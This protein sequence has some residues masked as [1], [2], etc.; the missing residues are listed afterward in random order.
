MSSLSFA[1]G[2]GKVIAVADVGSDSVGAAVVHVLPGEPA[3][4][5][6]TEKLTLPFEDRAPEQTI[7]GVLSLLDDACKKVTA[8]Y[9]AV[10]AKKRA[11][12][13]VGA[14]AVIHPKWTSTKTLQNSKV[15][16]LEERITEG[17]IEGLARSTIGGE[18]QLDR[19]KLIEASVVSVELNE[20]KVRNIEGKHAHSILV[21]T[22]LSECEPAIRTG[23]TET[24]RRSFPSSAPILRSA[25]HA[26]FS[27]LH[28]VA[29]QAR[30]QT[31]VAIESDS[32]NCIVIRKDSVMEHI[33]VAEGTSTILKKIASDALAEETLS[34]MRMMSRD[35][36]ETDACQKLSASLASIEPELARVF[37]EAFTRLTTIQRLPNALTIVAKPEFAPWLRAFFSRVDFGHFTVT[38][39]PFAPTVLSAEG[40]ACFSEAPAD[41]DISVLLA[42]S[43]VNMEELHA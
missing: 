34:L 11:R 39:Q 7:S 17:I 30:N 10:Y 43:F 12:P 38:T 40:L 13:V 19:S 24:L 8:K 26:L 6:V 1:H 3:A 22:L 41:T 25:T 14:Y 15:F 37:G 23:V 4:I 32:T 28:E 31:I 5:L 42:A 16:P 35:A 29:P 21:S 9:A 20:Y 18:Q 2:S 27:V 36:C 33:A